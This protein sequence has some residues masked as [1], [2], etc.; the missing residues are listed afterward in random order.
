MA[1]AV[2]TAAPQFLD[3]TEYNDPID[4][5]ESLVM[6]QLHDDIELSGKDAY[7]VYG[8]HKIVGLYH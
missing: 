4:V 1:I 5:M 6:Q 3:G 2:T 7:A 8:Y